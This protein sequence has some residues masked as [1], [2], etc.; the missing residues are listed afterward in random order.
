MRAVRAV[1]TLSIASSLLLVSCAPTAPDQGIVPPDAHPDGYPDGRARAPLPVASVAVVADAVIVR[2]DMAPDDYYVVEGSRKASSWMLGSATTAIEKGRY[3][4][5]FTL[6]PFV[7]GFMGGDEVVD[8]ALDIGGLTRG[9]SPPF[10]VSPSVARH[11]DYSDAL[12]A[13]LRQVASTDV[14]GMG[15][16]VTYADQTALAQPDWGL[17]SKHMGTDYLLVA[18]AG[19]V[20]VSGGK[21]TG[22]FCLSSCL[23]AAW[24]VLLNIIC[25][26]VTGG[27]SEGEVSTEM[28][29]EVHI[30][31]QSHLMSVVQ[32]FDA[33]TGDV[34]WTSTMTYVD[35]DPLSRGFYENEWAPS[36]L[37]HVVHL[38]RPRR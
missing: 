17:L 33:R 27:D 3:H 37:Q 18:V 25:S 26:A 15:P 2:D 30:E 4:V 1:I 19:G 10:F 14:Q 8:V 36:L 22:E 24:T 29:G 28:Y 34:V 23:S 9:Q 6:A 32:L 20:S 7:G 31:T 11:A 12:V 38:P 5:D 21:Q 16:L 13:V 35:I